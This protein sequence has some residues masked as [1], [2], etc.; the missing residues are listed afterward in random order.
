MNRAL[1]AIAAFA[2]CAGQ[3]C[4][5]PES[6]GSDSTGSGNAGLRQPG[7]TAG[8]Y[9]GDVTST[10]TLTSLIQDPIVT[11]RT[12]RKI[13]EFNDQGIPLNRSVVPYRVG[14]VD[15]WG[16]QGS[17]YVRQTITMVTA[18]GASGLVTP[19]TDIL[20]DAEEHLNASVYKGTGE[21]LYTEIRQGVVQYTE[22]TYMPGAQSNSVFAILDT[23]EV[24]TL[25][26]LY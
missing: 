7:V 14:E 11:V 1:F 25:Y 10:V 19:Q 12:Y 18:L 22:T 8:V 4:S 5:T 6:T 24:G 20:F 9:A 3:T 23:K 15:E 2:V 13:V 17:T 21:R 26:R 16:S